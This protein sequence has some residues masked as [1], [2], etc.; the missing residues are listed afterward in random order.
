MIKLK[1]PNAMLTFFLFI[2]CLLNYQVITNFGLRILRM[3]LSGRIEAAFW[4]IDNIRILEFL[5]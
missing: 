1:I 2:K 4:G 3:C 5:D